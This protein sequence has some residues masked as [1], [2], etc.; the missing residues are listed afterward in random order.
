[1]ILPPEVLS[2]L[3]SYD[4]KRLDPIKHKKLIIGAVLNYGT[5]AAT[6]WLFA[7]YELIEI[8]RTAQTIPKG[9][10]DKRSLALWSTVLDI[11]PQPRID[12]FQ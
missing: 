11:D 8:T 2:T 6:D 4:L 5:K 12:R 7:H 10:W 3:W 9:A 1:M